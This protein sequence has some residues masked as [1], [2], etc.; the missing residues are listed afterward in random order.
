MSPDQVW[1]FYDIKD[2]SDH[3]KTELRAGDLVLIRGR[4]V[5]H[6]D[7]LYFSLVRD[8]TCWRNR[9]YRKEQCHS[10]PDLNKKRPVAG[11]DGAL[12]RLRRLTYQR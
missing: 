9:C 1:S 3:L 4:R 10:C 8:V 5:D 2:A 6:L 12:V 7:R 11:S